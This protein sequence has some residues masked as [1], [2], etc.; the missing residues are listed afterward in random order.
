[1]RFT[2]VWTFVA[3]FGVVSIPHGRSGSSADQSGQRG[4]Q[5]A[6]ECVVTQSVD[7]EPPKDPTAD[8]FRGR[9]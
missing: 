2:E 8:P 4:S 9:W 7:E 1:M 5:S 3:V 6:S